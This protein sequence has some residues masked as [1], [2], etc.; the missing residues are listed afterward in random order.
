[1]SAK[2]NLKHKSSGADPRPQR[3]GSKPDLR[4]LENS[5]RPS[6][7]IE[8]LRPR[9]W[10]TWL[11]LALLRLCVYL[12]RPVVAW[13]GA[14]LGDLFYLFNQ[15]RRHV[16]QVNI[17]LC[18]P[19][20][21]PAA[22]ADLVRRHF[23]V[24]TQCLLDYGLCWWGR[25]AFLERYIRFRGLERYRAYLAQGRRIILLTGHSA[26]LDI[27][28]MMIS[29]HF[30]QLALVKPTKNKLID[31]IMSRGR[32]RHGGLLFTRDQGLRPVVRRVR[33][34]MGFYYLPDEDFGPENTVFA[35]FLGTES[36]TLTTLGRLA[37]LCDALVVPCYTRRLSARQGYEVVFEPALENFPQGDPVADAACM[38]QALER[39]VRAAPEQYMWTFKFLKTRPGGAPSPY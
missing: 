38:N 33:A 15:K 31:W 5:Y 21:A 18:F 29:Q 32:I 3:R 25:R 6:F 4:V 37:R 36:A 11:F 35:P 19:E 16:A 34:G 9:Y 24:Y 39:A 2:P 30:P 23:R 17:A 20:L 27:G 28:G 7:L 12:P 14:V 10:G 13:F 22:R 26:A 1:M 8:F